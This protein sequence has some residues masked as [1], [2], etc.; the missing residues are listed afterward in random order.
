MTSYRVLGEFDAE[1]EADGAGAEALAVGPLAGDA[2]GVPV[3]VGPVVVGRPRVLPHGERD[4]LGRHRRR[5]HVGRRQRR[6]RR[7]HSRFWISATLRFDHGVDVLD[8]IK[9][10]SVTIYRP[11]FLVTQDISPYKPRFVQ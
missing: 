8:V 1:S 4:F 3:E 2:G 6:R 5:R 9:A 7:V 10:K 11:F